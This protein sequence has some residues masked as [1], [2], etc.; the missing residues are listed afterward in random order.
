MSNDLNYPALPQV[1]DRV[2][3]VDADGN[4]VAVLTDDQLRASPLPLPVGAATEL[5]ISKL[6]AALFDDNNT[7]AAGNKGVLTQAVRK[8]D[9]AAVS[10][11]GNFAP[12]LVDSL[13]RLKVSTTL[14]AAPATVA[15]ITTNGGKVTMP[16]LSFGAAL[17]FCS[18]T[19]A[20]SNCIFEGSVDSTDG[21]N[22]N[23]FG[24]DAKR[25]NANTV[26]T[27]TGVL[28]GTPAYAWRVNTCGFKYLRVRATAFTSGTQVWTLQ[29]VA[30]QSDPTPASQVSGTQPV[31]G[32]LTS[33]GTTTATPATPT[34]SLV[35]SAATTNSTLVKNAAGTLYGMVISN[36]GA[37]A[38]FVKLYN[39]ATAP[40]VGTSAVVLTIPVP[41]G[42][43]VSI[44]WGPLG[45]RFGTGIGLAITNLAPDADTTAVSLG[46]VKVATSFI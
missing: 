9:E 21:T 27:T 41:P 32:S 26:E 34:A 45:M 39:L 2:I 1:P 35:N 4:T 33:A 37:A 17:L 3:L 13:G 36:T 22:G 24:I 18:G 12:L 11:N 7:W 38:A 23:W 43:T 28:G 15:N 16:C 42:S 14:A 30:F 5:T 20:G 31:S 8:D 19:F 46:Q 40:V 29:P 44:N 10:A 25:T 6:A